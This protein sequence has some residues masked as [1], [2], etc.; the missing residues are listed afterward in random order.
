MANQANEAVTPQPKFSF[1]T[2]SEGAILVF[3]AIEDFA[4]IPGAQEIL[5]EVN[6]QGGTPQGLLAYDVLA[7][8]IALKTGKKETFPVDV[9]AKLQTLSE[10]LVPT[11]A[12]VAAWLDL[13][14]SH[15]NDA[16]KELVDVPAERADLIAQII[17]NNPEDFVSTEVA[18]AGEMTVTFVAADTAAEPEKV[19]EVVETTEEVAEL[20]ADE[21][22]QAETTDPETGVI[23]ETPVQT[24]A[25]AHYEIPTE[26][27]VVSSE[28][29]GNLLGAI[30]DTSRANAD[31]AAANLVNANTIAGTQR[32]IEL[33]ANAVAKPAERVTVD[34]EVVTTP[35]EA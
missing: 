34:A 19:T 33:L 16:A 26:G 15:I 20:T 13:Q 6:I 25:L 17:S 22:A 27:L 1:Y 7:T 29:L 28:G 8:A 18:E 21:E 30:K 35:A 32:T 12:L 11:D 23:A 3:P 2:T 4:S 14:D 10:G 5:Q 31:I 9:E 24:D